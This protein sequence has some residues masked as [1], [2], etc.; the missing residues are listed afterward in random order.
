VKRRI[1]AALVGL[2][3]GGAGCRA[4]APP[5]DAG[6]LTSWMR[7]QY[8]LVR[9]ERL[10]PPVAS[11]V[12]AYG[13]VALYEGLAAGSPQL[14]S[15]A[16]QLNGLRELPRPERDE[17]YDWAVVAVSA[18]TT[19]LKV[20]FQ[21]GLPATQVKIS[22]LA[23]SQLAARRVSP[24]VRDRSTAYGAALG[25]AIADWAAGDRFLETRGLAWKP[26]TGRRYWVNTAEP[27]QYGV[28]S[29]SAVSEAVSLS[30]PANALT[31][32]AASER[33]LIV[34]RPKPSVVKTLPALN[35]AGVTEPYWG[36]LRPFV[37]TAMDECAPPPPSS[38]SEAPGSAFYREVKAVYDTSR[39]LTPEQREIALYWADN[40]GE[41]G[42]PPG[43]W[44][45]IASQLVGALDLDAERTAE[46]LMLTS[47]AM[48]DAFISCWHEKFSWSLIRPVSYIR[49][50]I[51]PRWHTLIPTPPFP[52]YT[53]GHA[54]Q[55]GAAA[56]V[57]TA[58]FGDRPFTD[59]THVSIGRPVRRLASFRAAADEVARS[60]LYAGIHYPISLSNGIAQGECIA[61]RV[62]DRVKTRA[63][64]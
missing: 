30:N 27:E 57:L 12:F 36:R 8:A 3:G 22:Q 52:E 13:A 46:M 1:L 25:H 55:S 45:L 23:D 37:L 61:R 20:L 59:S 47:L 34:T 38:Y 32:G 17:R 40:P 11:R 16:G 63:S 28:Q 39:T 6:I 26:P 15:L 29:L 42:T 58:L 10:S 21:E 31:Q 44:V 5:V 64:Q 9:A 50:V 18:E 54:V 51:D 43:H 4:A 41:T 56:G 14:R 2:L 35:P 62:M 49:R 33:A 60:R 24:A 19:L 48:A 53:A 7:A